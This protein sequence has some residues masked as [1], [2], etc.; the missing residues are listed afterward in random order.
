MEILIRPISHRTEEYAMG[1]CYSWPSAATEAVSCT[2][3]M[4]GF[5]PMN[6]VI[7]AQGWDRA[8]FIGSGA[9][10]LRPDEAAGV[11]VHK[12]CRPLLLTTTKTPSWNDRGQATTEI[13]STADA[14]GCESLCMTHFAFLPR[15]FPKGALKHCLQMAAR[16]GDQPH[17][18]RVIVDVDE[19]HILEAQKLLK[20]V[21][22]NQAYAKR[23]NLTSTQLVDWAHAGS[24]DYQG[25]LAGEILAKS[26]QEDRCVEALKWLILASATRWQ[27]D[28]EEREDKHKTLCQFIWSAMPEAQVNIANRLVEVWIEETLCDP[29]DYSAFVPEFRRFIGDCE[30]AQAQ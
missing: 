23:H 4:D 10:G 18:K 28:S 17:M 25:W 2:Y 11:L 7:T 6:A 9:L 12:E 14:E 13:I 21:H 16:A 22:A 5:S 15:K 1:H 30:T 27:Q 3:N 19:R 29:V 8:N 24:A 26:T 20:G